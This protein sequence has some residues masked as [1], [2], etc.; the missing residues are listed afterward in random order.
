MSGSAIAR[1]LLL[2]STA[3]FAEVPA[4]RVVIGVVP[5]KTAVPCIGITEVAGTDRQNVAGYRLRQF[6]DAGWWTERPQTKVTELVQLTVLGATYP[7]CKR[8]MKAARRACRDFVGD[9]AG[10]TAVTCRLDGKGPDFQTEAGIC[11]Q[12]Q[13]LRITYDESDL[14]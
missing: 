9:V 2:A 3:L 6:D 4:A 12:T 11:G 13:D 1:G 5:Q 14:T 8:V 10:F 7:E